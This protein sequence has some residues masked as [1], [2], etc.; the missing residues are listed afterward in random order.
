MRDRRLA[1]LFVVRDQRHDAVEDHS[2]SRTR[3]R[4]MCSPTSSRRLPIQ[5]LSGGIQRP[6]SESYSV[7]T[8]FQPGAVLGGLINE[9]YGAAA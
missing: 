6:T 8:L 9:Y 7:S 2:V 5:H 3:S 1:S 4:Q